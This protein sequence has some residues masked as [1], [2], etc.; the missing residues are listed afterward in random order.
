MMAN[1]KIRSNRRSQIWITDVTLSII[2]FTAASVIAFNII[3]NSFSVTNNYE[4]IRADASR[5]SE[6]LLSEGT[7]QDWNQTNVIRPGLLTGKR[8]N[9]TKVYQAMNMTNT[10]Y[11]SFKPSL[12][13]EN[14]FIIVFENRTGGIMTF[15]D[16][17]SIGK[18]DTGMDKTSYPLFCTLNMTGVE[19]DDLVMIERFILYNSDIAKMVIYMWK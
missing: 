2:L 9:A 19:Y 10:S 1:Q 18:P 16:Y 17:C 15:Q 8:L 4:R 5:I 11:Q 6:Y 13:T 3:M 7:P 12:Q 14:D